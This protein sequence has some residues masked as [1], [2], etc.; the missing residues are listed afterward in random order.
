MFDIYLSSFIYTTILCDPIFKLRLTARMDNEYTRGQ[1]FPGNY[2]RPVVLGCS[3][4]GR[5]LT[6]GVDKPHSAHDF[7]VA[8]QLNVNCVWDSRKT[9]THK[10]HIVREITIT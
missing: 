4:Y 2:T 6:L 3:E 5:G 9:V 8:T 10:G 7:G 1:W